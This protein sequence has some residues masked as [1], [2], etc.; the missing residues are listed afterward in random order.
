MMRISPQKRHQRRNQLKRQFQL[1]LLKPQRKS[2]LNQ[3]GNV[4]RGRLPHQQQPVPHWS[5]KRNPSQRQR[6]TW[7]RKSKRRTI[8]FLKRLKMKLRPSHRRQKLRNPT[9][10][11]E[12][13]KK[14]RKMQKMDSKKPK[15]KLQIN[16][17]RQSPTKL[18]KTWKVP[19]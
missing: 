7:Q 16:R 6:T 15:N 12:I 14:N 1:K 19:L 4:L 18:S 5:Q 9:I 2:Y 3:R 17:N 11:L 10:P 13:T 8:R